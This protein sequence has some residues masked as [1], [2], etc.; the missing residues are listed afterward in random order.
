MADYLVR[1]NPAMPGFRE[2]LHAF[3]ATR[4]LEHSPHA[5]HHDIFPVPAGR[6]WPPRI[7]RM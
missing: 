2:T 3:V 5:F 6:W 1:H 4:R 7:Q